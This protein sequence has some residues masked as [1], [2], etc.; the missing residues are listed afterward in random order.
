MTDL[1]IKKT[2]NQYVETLRE[3][4]KEFN[5]FFSMI[6][7]ESETFYI[8]GGSLRELYF[9][10]SKNIRDIDII[11]KGLDIEKLE[12]FKYKKNRFGSYKIIFKTIDV[13]IW[14]FKEN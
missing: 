4:D 8:L 12:I 14:D 10:N 11:T 1:E 9:N 2:L 6:E 7:E 13:D 5:E 3:N